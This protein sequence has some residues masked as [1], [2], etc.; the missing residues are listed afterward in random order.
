MARR[1]RWGK[2][3]PT[4]G[5]RRR[6]GKAVR[7]LVLLIALAGMMGGVASRYMSDP[8]EGDTAED[9]RSSKQED[10][11]RAQ[12]RRVIDG[13]TVVVRLDGGDERL[14]YIGI[15]T[16][17]THH[18]TVPEQ[19]YGR[20]ATEA[21]R[22]LVTDAQ[23]WL[24]FDVQQRDDYGRLLAYVYLTDGTFVN[25]ALVES[26]YAR[27]MTVPPNVRHADLFQRLER[28]ARERDAG[29]W[30]LR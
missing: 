6:M 1:R 14:R 13:D 29:L 20:E 27:V 18:P 8:W 25:A 11:V 5:G 9:D 2:R 16:P 23:V 17:E 24:Q 15:N 10:R 4:G 3:G 22:R 12:V 28:Q 26:G 30:G 19:P 21:N 7:V